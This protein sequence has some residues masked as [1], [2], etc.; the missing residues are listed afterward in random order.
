[1]GH[2]RHSAPALAE[3]L[4]DLFLGGHFSSCAPPSLFIRAK[5]HSPVAPYPAL[6]LSQGRLLSIWL[7][8]HPT[9]V[10]MHILMYTLPVHTLCACPMNRPTVLPAV[11]HFEPAPSNF[12]RGQH[13]QVLCGPHKG[14]V[15]VTLSQVLTDTPDSELRSR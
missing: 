8:A 12:P 14:S 6:S 7:D 4:T 3:V 1:M 13:P 9:Y 15:G 2:G 5:R 10:C 11:T